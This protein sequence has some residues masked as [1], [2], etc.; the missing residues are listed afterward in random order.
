M[1]RNY[2]LAQ[3]IQLPVKQ[4]E[5]D[6]HEK[7]FDGLKAKT[8][9]LIYFAKDLEGNYSMGHTPLDVRDLMFMEYTLHKIIQRTV[10]DHVGNDE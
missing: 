2:L 4:D 1:K 9:Q 8:D 10:E 6:E 3:I 7:F 5:P